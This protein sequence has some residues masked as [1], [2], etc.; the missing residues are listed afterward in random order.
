[1]CQIIKRNNKICDNCEFFNNDNIDI[2]KI[3]L[4]DHDPEMH[5]PGYHDRNQDEYFYLENCPDFKE[6]EDVKIQDTRSS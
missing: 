1:M 5:I 6:K 2:W 4:K 3:C